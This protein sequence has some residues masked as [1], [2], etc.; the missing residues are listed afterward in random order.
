MEFEAK[1]QKHLNK[2]TKK[3][4]PRLFEMAG[5]KKYLLYVSSFFAVLSSA[6]SLIPYIS[7]YKV[8]E[9]LLKNYVFYSNN[10]RDS[11]GM[12]SDSQ[13]M[14]KWGI[15]S[16]V[17][18]VL[19]VVFQALS[20][21]FS[22]IAA[23]NILYNIRVLMAEHI[24]FLPLGYL[25]NTTT[26]AISKTLEQNVEKI[27]LFI[28]HTIPDLVKVAAICILAFALFFRYNIILTIVCIV[29]FIL[30]L[31]MQFSGMFS[32]RSMELQKQYFDIAEKISGSVVQFIYGMPV[33]KIFG[34]TVFSFHKL[35]DD[36]KK[37]REI[38]IECCHI[39]RTGMCFFIALLES[40]VA[41]IIPVGLLLLSRNEKDLALA[42]DYIFFIIMSPGISGPLYSLLMI[43]SS[44]ESINEGNNRI[45]A[46]LNEDIITQ[47]ES[48][49]IP[50][51]YNVTFRDVT[52]N[53]KES[54][55]SRS[56]EKNVLSNV[57]FEA[58]NGKITALVGPSGSGKSTIGSL[59]PRFWDVEKGEICIGGINVK[60]ITYPDLMNIISF[61]FQD[62]FLFNDTIYN[63]I[64][65][66]RPN[67]TKEDVIA[68]A[69]AAQCHDFIENLPHQYETII[70]S[71]E[72]TE[73][74]LLS[75]GEQ[76]RVCIARAI[77]KNSPILVLDEATA[78]SDP[79]NEYNIQLA[80]KE[81][82][83]NK[84]V[85]VI[86][87]NLNTIKSADNI[88]VVKEGEIVEQGKHE[89]LLSMNGL[90]TS[91]WNAYVNSS[92]WFITNK[93]NE[94]D[95]SQSYNF[96][97]DE[98]TDNNKEVIDIKDAKINNKKVVKRNEN[99]FSDNLNLLYNITCGHPKRIYSAILYTIL[100]NF[101][102]MIPFGLAINVVQT[103]FEAYNGSGDPLNKTKIWIISGV[104]IAF[105]FIIYLTQ[106]PAYNHCFEEAYK[107]SV[108]GRME[109]AE[110]VRRLPIGTIYAKDPGEMV[111]LL[112]NDYLLIETASSHLV[113]QLFGALV[114]PIVAFIFLLFVDWRLDLAAF[115]PFPLGLFIIILATSLQNN[116]S[117]KQLLAKVEAGNSF[118]E[119]MKGIRCIKAYNLIGSKFERLEHAFH[120]LM[121]E[122]IKIEVVLGP[123]VSLSASIT[124]SGIFFMIIVGAY[125]L[126]NG[127][128]TISTFVLFLVIGS[129]VFDP[130]VKSIGN[131]AEIRYSAV[132]GKRI[133][134]F[135][136]LPTMEGTIDV[137]YEEKKDIVFKNVSFKYLDE[138]KSTT[139][140][141]NREYDLK[142][143]NIKMAQGSLTALV[144]P[145]GS[146]KTTIL[147]LI[148]KFYDVNSGKITYAGEDIS[149]IDPEFYMKNISIVF[150]DVYLFQDTIANNIRFGRENAT[151]ED[152]VQAAKKSCAHDFIMS[153]PKGY[154]T[155][156][157]EGGCTLSGGEK[158]RIS[159]ARAILKDSPVVLLDEATSS[160][161]PENEVEVQKAI[162]ELI[163]GR[164]VIVISHHLRTI[165]EAD[166][167]IVLNEGEV[168]EQG[169]HEQLMN[170]NGVYKR[171][172]DVQDKYNG[173][174]MK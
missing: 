116:L 111:S 121:N 67:A 71:A 10:N 32:K 131:I 43:V 57:S 72:D 5:T 160:L 22:H 163:A 48:P 82:I 129:R 12:E 17:S 99:M 165:K 157:G 155:M 34:K 74:V 124:H 120:K 24:G 86:A 143:I 16:I 156:V 113:P 150:Q 39:Y 109:L 88:L 47:P 11:K 100:A 101:V 119:Y 148:S 52:F 38:S 134:D 6:C 102:T 174:S 92:K 159:I 14:I 55:K 9:V 138:Q 105:I 106:I 65:I 53:Y 166:N 110:H 19:V 170:N 18:F 93:S 154:D 126:K 8:L 91:M 114:M 81:L 80:L 75:G 84:T 130:L 136:A 108:S 1:Y 145:S 83:K 66:G 112:M 68:A 103:V 135:L 127:E 144:G 50:T 13:I 95:I 20:L 31:V 104:L 96:K 46:I 70:G 125:L 161:D 115:L 94:K 30:A 23:F 168:V 128:I 42:L 142:N 4:I 21:I 76:Q 89:Q 162:S 141:G 172:W 44:I 64:I 118:Q 146:G 54:E 78:Y 59:I 49:K 2:Y 149:K 63:N 69:K 152:I 56:G 167:I 133:Q 171:L 123:I 36:L 85:I 40:F 98:D 27:E 73:G 158:Q 122:S 61:V 35:A 132:A 164:T 3:G 25:S 15:I 173:W 7:V 117:L 90:Y 58:E 139:I 107:A 62:T 60:D 51:K 147:K 29:V 153:L 41:F 151:K 79:E 45:D 26:G 33:V 140:K 28:A 97:I 137:N 169:T 37:Y 77:L 87:H